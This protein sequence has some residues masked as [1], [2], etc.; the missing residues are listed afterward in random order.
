MKMQ[1]SIQLILLAASLIV[2]NGCHRVSGSTEVKSTQPC[3][4]ALASQSGD[5]IIDQEIAKLQ[6]KIRANALPQQTKA[7]VE[8]LGWSFVEKARV[9]FDPGYFKLAEQCALCMESKLPGDEPAKGP[10]ASE[11]SI[12]AAS[13]LLRGHALHSLHRFAEAE[14]LARELVE[15]RGL[16][17]DFGL[18]GDVLM[19]QGKLDDAIMAYQK[20]MEQRP[21]PQAYSRAAHVRWL[22]GD[23]EGARI[24]MRLSAQSAGQG[25]SES[26]AWA[27]SRLALFELQ[28]GNTKRA[29]SM[30]GLALELQKDYAPALLAQGRILLA[31]DKANDAIAPLEKAAELNRL[32]EYQWTLADALGAA[33]RADEATKI[34][35][36]LAASGAANDPRTFALYLATRGRHPETALKL[37]EEELKIRR[38]VYTLDAQAWAQAAGGNAIEAW[39]TMQSAL[40]QNTQDARLFL[41][42]AIIASQAGEKSSARIYASK[43]V[44]IKSML[45]PGE[46]ARLR[47]LKTS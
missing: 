22:K 30:C 20:M 10:L 9:S 4:I 14:K 13:L 5:T 19:E 38:D 18:L 35:S 8:K 24:L 29:L 47:D 34:E 36:Q 27:W 28:A 37:I 42:A 45:L 39:K 44:K 16:A 3:E 26:A 7:L 23:L 6:H 21:G 2:L 15:A 46:K 12:R 32:P 17:Y 25:D 11:K 33:G 40:A 31:Q 41:H 43:A 1:R